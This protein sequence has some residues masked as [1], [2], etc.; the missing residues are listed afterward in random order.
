MSGVKWVEMEIDSARDSHEPV[1]VEEI[2]FCCSVNQ[3]VFTWTALL[4]MQGSL[5]VSSIAPLQMASLWGL[6]AMP[7]HSRSR[8]C[9]CER[10]R[11]GCISDME[12]SA[13]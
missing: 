4:D 3:V 8:K 13:T 2:L 9:V 5:L 6:I 1:L 10:S 12:I 11:I 7:R